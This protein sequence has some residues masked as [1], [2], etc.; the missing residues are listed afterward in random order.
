MPGQLLLDHVL[1]AQPQFTR[2]RRQRPLL[3]KVLGQN[4]RTKNVF[5]PE[6]LDLF[7][8]LN[9]QPEVVEFPA[10]AVKQT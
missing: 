9:T 4:L 2:K 3:H 10:G 8:A 1:H 5:L 6:L 7:Q